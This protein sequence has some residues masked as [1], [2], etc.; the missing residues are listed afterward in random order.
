MTAA[1]RWNLNEEQEH[2]LA[3]IESFAGRVGTWR[4]V[5][6]LPGVYVLEFDGRPA[7]RLRLMIPRRRGATLTTAGGSW[8]LAR[9]SFW[10]AVIEVRRA[11]QDAAI[12]EYEPGVWLGLAYRGRGTLQFDDGTHYEWRRTSFWKSRY[13]FFDDQ[14]VAV[15]SVR[16]R[17][18]AVRRLLEVEL[19]TGAAR[20]RHLPELVGLAFRMLVVR[21]HA[22]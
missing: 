10:S 5:G 3:P 12:A 18:P 13:E 4:R 8:E 1:R 7:A 11:G 15:V 14:G 19:G 22:Y 9:R 6:F 17:F 21:P 16:P 20:A 2:P